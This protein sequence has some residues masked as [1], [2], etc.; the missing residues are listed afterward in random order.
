MED[1]LKI[2]EPDDTL[3]VVGESC[4]VPEMMASKKL[5]KMKIG[6]I[7]EVLTDHQPA[8]DVTLPSLCKNLGYPYMIL[9]DGDLFR[10]RILKVR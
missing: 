7:L 8:V 2:K 9:K 3:D 1:V 5:K 10:F 6:Q 4:P